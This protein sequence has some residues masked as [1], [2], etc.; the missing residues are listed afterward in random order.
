MAYRSAFGYRLMPGSDHTALTST[1]IWTGSQIDVADGYIHMSPPPEVTAA[2][3]RYFARCPDLWLLRVRLSA[4]TPLCRLQWDLVAD[5][6]EFPHLYPA[7]GLPRALL[8]LN[9]VEGAWHLP[10]DAASE[11]FV[12][13]SE[14]LASLEADGE[15]GSNAAGVVSERIERPLPATLPMASR[16]VLITGGTSGLG[17]AIA[18]ALSAAGARVLV[19]SSSS[20]KVAAAVRTLGG[21]AQGIVMDVSDEAS[22]AAAFAKEVAPACGGALWGLVNAAGIIR[23]VPAEEESADGWRKVMDVNL[24]GAFLCAK[25][26][27]PLLRSG[28]LPASA[29]APASGGGILNI[30]SI[31]SRV[32]LSDVTAY[33]CS[34]AGL[35][36]LTKCLASDWA[37]YN[38]RVNALLPGWFPTD[39]NRA[40]I[41]GTPRGE[42]ALRQTPQ[43][44]FGAPQ[45]LGGAALFLMSEAASFVT[46]ATLEVDGGF[47]AR[48]VGPT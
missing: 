20:D 36:A 48:G 33:A 3:S 25:A 41:T 32:A 1:G 29:T 26:A 31:A 42:W 4:C 45:E 10:W 12:W 16:T 19:A 39:I 24:T 35:E 9:A 46:G 11:G 14:V 47:L 15:G 40:A 5:R 2:A 28:V 13:P 7:G 43:A 21:S 27:L 22:V 8:P 23:R 37:R 6:A 34:K 18:Q 17:L 44:R 30:C 38:V